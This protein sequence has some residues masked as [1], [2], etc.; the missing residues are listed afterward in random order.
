MRKLTGVGLAAAS[1]ATLL[2][3]GCGSS[4]CAKLGPPNQA[5]LDVANSGAEVEIEVNG[6]F[7]TDVECE[8]QNGRWVQDRDR[9]TSTTRHR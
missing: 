8:L 6:R 1:A 7:G 9:H 3:T 4:P 5:Q 2:L